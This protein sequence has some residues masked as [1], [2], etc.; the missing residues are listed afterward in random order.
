[1]EAAAAAAVAASAAAVDVDDD[2]P[3][4]DAAEAAAAFPLDDDR[5]RGSGSANDVTLE[6]SGGA[7]AELLVFVAVVNS[8]ASRL[9]EGSQADAVQYPATQ[10]SE[11][12]I[13]ERA[14]Q[15]VF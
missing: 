12:D 10:R 5:V 4:D 1:L 14:V 11:A 13:L 8:I 7:M 15:V 3:D 6:D 2:G 9:Y